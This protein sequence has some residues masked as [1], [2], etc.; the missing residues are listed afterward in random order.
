M[1]LIGS[2]LPPPKTRV[3][4]ALRLNFGCPSED[5]EDEPGDKVSSR[6]FIGIRA[7]LSP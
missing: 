6:D 1:S 2:N 5:R 3:A 4:E 7:S